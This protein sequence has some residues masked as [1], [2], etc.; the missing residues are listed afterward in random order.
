MPCRDL[1]YIRMHTGKLFLTKNN[2]PQ[3]ILYTKSRIQLYCKTFL[4]ILIII[5]KTVVMKQILIFGH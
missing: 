5:K 3:Y 1:Y 2:Y 4:K